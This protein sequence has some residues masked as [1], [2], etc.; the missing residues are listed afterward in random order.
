MTYFVA[1]TILASD[2]LSLSFIERCIINIDDLWVLILHHLRG[3]VRNT[4]PANKTQCQRS[5]LLNMRAEGNLS[6]LSNTIL[7]EQEKLM[8]AV[9]H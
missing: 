1:N 8:L 3:V 6:N 9:L 4:G 5:G 7:K 2:S